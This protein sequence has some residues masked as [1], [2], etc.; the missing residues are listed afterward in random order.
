LTR[1]RA[2]AFLDAPFTDHG[3]RLA[4]WR[5]ARAVGAPR[6]VGVASGD[7]AGDRF[8]PEEEWFLVRDASALPLVSGAPAPPRRGALLCWTRSPAD[9][10]PVHT[11][12]E[13]EEARL[14]SAGPPDA[15][16]PVVGFR[17]DAI[18][19]GAGETVG[20]LLAR[21]LASPESWVSRP[22][23]GVFDAG[24]AAGER[25]EVTSRLP[26]SATRLLDVGCGA[27][28]VGDAARRSRP[29][30][31]VCGIERDARAAGR[32]RTRLDRVFEADAAD[33]LDSLVASGE[34]FDAF[35]LADVLEHLPDP[36]AV[37]R[38]CRRLA[39]PGATLVASVPNV[40]HLSLVRD[41][42]RGRFDYVP[43]GL[44]D[45]GHLR[46]FTRETLGELLAEAG[47][48]VETVAGEAGA[49]SPDSSSF[50]RGLAGWESADHA[51]LATYQ[52]IAVARAR[53]DPSGS[54]R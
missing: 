17:T 36:V 22:G 4:R 18:A 5:W 21:V 15:S 50:L 48:T 8:R 33:A 23:F 11:L 47:W 53:A 52:W 3:S 28:E 34:T 24:G 19:P 31:E 20:E 25:P 32:A 38:A 43:S 12:R 2:V 40:T 13:L 41:L 54:S 44:L 37:L 29:G 9:A 39:R 14:G 27:G 26:A 42:V 35:L 46:W 45:A 6:A 51:A 16:A 10:P 49:P 30:L 1:S 7:P